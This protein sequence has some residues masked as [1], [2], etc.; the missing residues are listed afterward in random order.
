MKEK[1]NRN[2][3]R[4]EENDKIHVSKSVFQTAREMQEKQQEELKQKQLEI[5]KK[6]AEQEKKKRE[7]YERKLL[8]EKKELIRL[9]QGAIEE[10]ELTRKEEEQ[11]IKL[12]FKQKIAN[13]IYHNKWWFGIGLCAVLIVSV[14]IYDIATKKKP[15]I[16]M[17][18]ITQND[19]VGYNEEFHEYIEG[20]SEDF[21]N[22]D[23]ILA[24]VFYIPYTDDLNYNYSNGIDNKLTAE[25]QTNEAVIVLGGEKTSQ[26]LILEDIFTKLDEIYPDNPNVDGYKFYLKDTPFEER[27]GLPEGTITDD[28]FLAIRKPQKL[29]YSSEKA[30]QETYDKDFPVFDKI[31]KDLSE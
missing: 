7:E 11:V 21:N 15:D 10:S 1:D 5:E 12:N 6:Y 3:D 27:L 17:L 22:N 8:E 25:F 2:T 4:N 14:L 23:E 20:F 19:V 24:S 28:M 13:F 18:M 9:K 26:I 29:L 31:I 30:L 16:V